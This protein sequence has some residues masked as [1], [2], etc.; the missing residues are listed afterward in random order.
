MDNDGFD[1]DDVLTCLRK[2]TAHGP[3]NNGRCNV[4]HRGLHIRTAVGG[5]EDDSDGWAGLTSITVITV[6]KV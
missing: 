5:L 6:M 4:V 1:H 3:E 2:G